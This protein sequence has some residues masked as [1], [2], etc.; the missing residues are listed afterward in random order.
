MSNNIILIGTGLMAQEY[1]KV[2]VSLKI[3]FTVVGRGANSAKKFEEITGIKPLTGG[4]ESYLNNYGLIDGS[5]ILITTGTE[6]LLNN[7]ILAIR[8]GADKILI[9]KPAAL[10]I[11]ELLGYESE[12]LNSKT[13]IFVGYNRR[14]YRSV[15]EAKKIINNDGGLKTMHFEFT[16]WSHKIENLE[17]A[18]GVKENWFFANSTHVIDLAFYFANSPIE[19]KTFVNKG[20]LSWHKNSNFVGAGKT[21]SNVLFSYISNWEGPGRWSID[22]RTEKHRL[23]LEPLEKLKIQIKGSLEFKELE[24]DYSID[25][26]YKPG[27]FNQINSFLKGD[28]KDLVAIKSHIYNSKYIYSKINL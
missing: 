24:L 10:S 9:E 22:L 25:E 15:T 6:T 17:K 23:L 2:L 4:F 20:N 28:Y 26:L 18:N 12:I 8:A 7:L 27:L 16:E 19:L 11:E 13:E 21:E 1:C 3:N 5:K 14:F